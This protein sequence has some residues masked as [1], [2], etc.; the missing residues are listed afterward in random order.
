MFRNPNAN[1]LKRGR[2]NNNNNNNNNSNNNKKSNPSEFERAQPLQDITNYLVDKQREDNYKQRLQHFCAALRYLVENKQNAN[3]MGL[4]KAVAPYPLTVVRFSSNRYGQKFDNL[5]NNIPNALKEI[6]GFFNKVRLSYET[7]PVLRGIYDSVGKVQSPEIIGILCASGQILSQSSTIFH[8]PEVQKNTNVDNVPVSVAS[9]SNNEIIASNIPTI[10]IQMGLLFLAKARK[11]MDVLL[12]E[13]KTIIANLLANFEKELLDKT[14]G[15]LAERLLEIS[16]QMSSNKKTKRFMDAEVKKIEEN[17]ALSAEVKTES[18]K[19]IKDSAALSTQV[20]VPIYDSNLYKFYSLS[21]E[22]AQRI[23]GTDVQHN[24]L[25]CRSEMLGSVALFTEA[26]FDKMDREYLAYKFESHYHQELER[27]LKELSNKNSGAKK[28]S[29]IYFAF[30]EDIIK[31]DKSAAENIFSEIEAAEFKGMLTKCAQKTLWANNK[32]ELDRVLMALKTT[33]EF[34]PKLDKFFYFKPE[35]FLLLASGENTIWQQLEKMY[36]RSFDDV[37]NPLRT[38]I[39]YYSQV[40]DVLISLEKTMKD[41]PAKKDKFAEN[42]IKLEKYKEKFQYQFT[43]PSRLYMALNGLKE[44]AL[45]Q[46]VEDNHIEDVDKSFNRFENAVAMLAI[47][48]LVTNLIQSLEDNELK[49]EGYLEVRGGAIPSHLKT[50]LTEL[51]NT[52]IYYRDESL[53]IGF[54]LSTD[55]VYQHML[56]NV[57]T[58]INSILDKAKINLGTFPEDVIARS[59]ALTMIKEMHSYYEKLAPKQKTAANEAGRASTFNVALN[60]NNN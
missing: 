45:N 1:T 27:K 15:F 53:M 43:R 4:E 34:L 55:T 5:K 29:F 11:I 38:I 58:S 25:Q 3:A 54:E 56:T 24:L 52:F 33:F 39:V 51:R 6:D 7:C 41:N 60:N 35:D 18:I 13:E 20:I 17:D 40:F 16:Q 26:L 46:K 28:V 36:R 42:K 22:S 44:K 30:E 19:E 8:G 49:I 32:K 2:D 57:L 59:V 10:T 9:G 12:S 48:N 23:Y 50:A 37:I 14:G 47:H 21:R 31:M